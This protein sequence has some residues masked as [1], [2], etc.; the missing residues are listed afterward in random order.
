MPKGVLVVMSTSTTCLGL[1]ALGK[2]TYSVLMSRT[3]Y[4]VPGLRS[5]TALKPM[6]INTYKGNSVIYMHRSMN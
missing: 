5:Y 1:R 3:L 6:L 2:S 4:R